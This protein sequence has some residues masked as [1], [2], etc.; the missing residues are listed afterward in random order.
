MS[1][2]SIVLPVQRSISGWK[3]RGLN[4]FAGYI[5]GVAKTGSDIH[6]GSFKRKPEFSRA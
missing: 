5:F 3:A 4:S 1:Q 2:P 6:A